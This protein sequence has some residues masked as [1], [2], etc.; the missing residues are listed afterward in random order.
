VPQS[1]W[2]LPAQP[3]T[4]GIT[5]DDVYYRGE[6]DAD[7]GELLRRAANRKGLASP[8]APRPASVVRSRVAA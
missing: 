7:F 4:E 3:G 2:T 6:R 8:A 1:V 5:P